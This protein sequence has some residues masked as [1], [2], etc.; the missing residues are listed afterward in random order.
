[1]SGRDYRQSA[2]PYHGAAGPIEGRFRG[3]QFAVSA[4]LKDMFD[5]IAAEPLP[6]RIVEVLR[7]LDGGAEDA[8]STNSQ[9]ASDGREQIAEKSVAT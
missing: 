7:R 9:A 5:E 4:A 3:E 6:R 8:R 1:M 2:R